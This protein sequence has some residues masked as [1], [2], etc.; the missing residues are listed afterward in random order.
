MT[1]ERPSTWRRLE[2]GGK[3]RA[4]GLRED[5][6]EDR[7]LIGVLERLWRELD[8]KYPLKKR[9]CTADNA[10]PSK[11]T[12]HLCNMPVKWV[13][14]PLFMEAIQRLRHF[15]MASQHLSELFVLSPSRITVPFEDLMS[16]MTLLHICTQ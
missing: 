13:Y 15:S 8:D 16:A 1:G 10:L 12:F 5:R 14:P 6:W 11:V 2:E 3:R 9:L 4:S 7:G